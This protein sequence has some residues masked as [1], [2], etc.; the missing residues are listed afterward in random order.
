MLYIHMESTDNLRP[1]TV[2][3]ERRQS[4]PHWPPVWK[5]IPRRRFRCHRSPSESPAG[6]AETLRT[7]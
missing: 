4:A 7:P 3:R 6:R 2:H 5:S 1:A